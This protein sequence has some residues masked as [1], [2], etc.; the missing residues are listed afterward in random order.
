MVAVYLV[1][2]IFVILSFVFEL[3]LQTY[4]V[5]AEL[6]TNSIGLGFIICEVIC[7]I[8][9]LKVLTHKKGTR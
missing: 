9:V 8:W 2:T 7:G 6:I 3:R 1:A 5:M 4:V